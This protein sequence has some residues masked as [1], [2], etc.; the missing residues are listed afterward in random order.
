MNINKNI[1]VQLNLIENIALFEVTP[2]C[3]QS[4]TISLPAWQ[5]QTWVC[6][7]SIVRQTLLTF[8]LSKS[9]PILIS[10]YYTFLQ[11]LVLWLFL[12]SGD[13]LY[14]LLHCG[15]LGLLAHGHHRW[16]VCFPWIF[17]LIPP[18][19][20]YLVV[21][22]PLNGRVRQSSA[23]LGVVFILLFAFVCCIPAL[24]FSTTSTLRCEF[25][26]NIN[27]AQFCL[28]RS[29]TTICFLLWP[30]GNPNESLSDQ[31]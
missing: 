19:F 29:G 16:E 6:A 10:S 2:A 23:L 11:D 15:H 12:L 4:Q 18:A 14:V 27:I 31:M 28:F 9:F 8:S 26:N 7:S 22:K 20:R 24:V 25:C 3:G 17:F 1:H 13:Q 5:L 30:D 21:M